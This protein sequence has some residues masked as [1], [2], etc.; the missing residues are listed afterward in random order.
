MSERPCTRAAALLVLALAACV[1][2]KDGPEPS[3]PTVTSPEPPRPAPA[4]ATGEPAR[5]S[6]DAGVES[7][8]S[9]AE[10]DGAVA[11]LAAMVDAEQDA[12]D[13]HRVIARVAG[14][15]LYLEDLVTLW[16]HKDS[17]AVQETLSELV[18]ASITRRDAVARGVKVDPIVLERRVAEV[19]AEL[20]RTVREGTGGM[21]TEEWIARRLGLHPGRYL[22]LLRRKTAEQILTERLVRLWFLEQGWARL[23]M[24]L[25][26]GED[27]LAEVQAALEAGEDF[28]NVARAKSTDSTA[29]DGGLIP[30]FVKSELSPMSQ[31]AFLSPVGEVAGPL[32]LQGRF[33]LILV[34]ELHEPRTGG[35]A[36]LGPEIER[37]LEEQLVT[38]GEY[39]QWEIF[40]QRAYSVDLRPFYELVGE[41][42]LE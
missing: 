30:A 15:E 23:R 4:A 10:A 5:R 32:E 39:V 13:A 3:G 28:A 29:E 25:V 24:I 11:A 9:E 31:L 38:A 22:E 42:P 2:P 20:D 34:E 37:G 36:A 35:W 6:G 40:I 14:E 18:V 12:L 21:P 16:L 19:R 8:L 1:S 41:P 7:A 17:D 33:V 26:E 27:A